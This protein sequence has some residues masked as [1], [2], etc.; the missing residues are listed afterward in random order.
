MSKA[1]EREHNKCVELK[2]D[3]NDVTTK[4]WKTHNDEILIQ[5]RDIKK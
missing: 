2:I 1:K 4:S 5:V 3:I